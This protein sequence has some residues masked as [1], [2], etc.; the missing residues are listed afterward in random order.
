MLYLSQNQRP[1]FLRDLSH[2]TTKYVEEQQNSHAELTHLLQHTTSYNILK[3]KQTKKGIVI[4][5]IA[6]MSNLLKKPR[7]WNIK[8]DEEIKAKEYNFTYQQKH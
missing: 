3:M 4:A 1:R 8:R 6:S 5:H 2:Y 7:N